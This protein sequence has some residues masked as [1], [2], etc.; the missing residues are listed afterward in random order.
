MS[1]T[2]TQKSDNIWQPSPAPGLGLEQVTLACFCTAD[3]SCG[4]EGVPFLVMYESRKKLGAYC[5]RCTHWIKWVKQD[6]VWMP[7][8]PHQQSERP[9]VVPV[10]N[11]TMPADERQALLDTPPSGLTPF[12]ERE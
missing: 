1:K 12:E 3:P 7:Q 4:W 11:A 9:P 2:A 6:L 8:L 10:S 5:P